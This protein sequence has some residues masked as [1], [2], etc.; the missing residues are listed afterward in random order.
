M[1][2]EGAGDD[3]TDETRVL[4]S[5]DA[6]ATEE[7]RVLG[8]GAAPDDADETRVMPPPD[9][10]PRDS[11][12]TFAEEA[13]VDERVPLP[14]ATVVE[15]VEEVRRRRRVPPY[16]PWL[17][18][19]LLLVLV[20]LGALWW[21]SRDGGKATVPNVVGEREASAVERVRD[22]DLEPVVSRRPSDRAPGVVFAQSPGAGSQ[23]DDGEAVNLLVSAGPRPVPVPSVVGLPANQAVERLQQASADFQVNQQQVVSNEPPG[24]VV[25]QSPKAGETAPANATIRLNVSKGTG[26]VKVPNV[27]GQSVE[28][29]T[30]S[31]EGAGLEASRVDVPS[32]EDA[33]TVVAQSPA[34]GSEVAEGSSVRI[35][36]STGPGTSTTGTSTGGT[37]TGGTAREVPVPDV[38]GLEPPE[39]TAQLRS[40]G[41]RVK[42]TTEPTNDPA[43]DGVVIRQDPSGGHNAKSGT[44]VSLVVG[45]LSG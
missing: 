9:R 32:S 34:A 27:V 16:W 17:L 43:Q 20:G 8:G 7:T 30:N 24:I 22:A 19:L 5:D 10:W 31:I 41:F 21:L 29:A 40:A 3:E 35:N 15:E 4:R 36:V 42:T 26:K 13:A 37:T 12:P 6:G 18:L 45:A 44:Q 14:P 25:A 33:G 1:P 38:V 11:D 28:Q 2:P 23:L 39:A